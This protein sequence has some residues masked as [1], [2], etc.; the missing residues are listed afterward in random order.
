MATQFEVLIGCGQESPC[1]FN[2]YSDFVLK[3]AAD[4]IDRRFPN[5]WGIQFDYRISHL[6]TNRTQKRATGGMN[7][8]Q[9]LR[10]ILYAD[11]A[12]LFCKTPEEAQEL[13]NIIDSTCRRFGLTISH[14]KTKTQVFNNDE[15]AKND[16]IISRGTHI[17]ENVLKFTY[18]GQVF[19]TT[20]STTDKSDTKCYTDHRIAMANAKFNELRSA[21][22]D[23]NIQLQTRRKILE[24]CVR[25]RLTYGL[26]A[27]YPKEAELKKLEG[28][29]SG[30]LRSM[31]KGGWKR[32]DPEEED[33]ENFSFVYS[34]ER[35][36]GITKAEPLR[37]Y[38]DTSSTSGMSAD[39][40]TVAS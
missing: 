39:Q 18:L 30:I 35:V 10:W 15:L 20:T 28:C 29:W 25:S 34:N 19:T 36:Q 6:C 40:V 21:L 14:K 7:G 31:V 23:T 12:V 11:D 2:Y 16:S 17:I 26:S 8:V 13:L 4:E 38:I 9:I 1:L 37:D 24:A 22:C 27:C 5:G 33:G 32:K 3:V